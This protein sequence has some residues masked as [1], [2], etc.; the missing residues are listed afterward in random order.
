[1][2]VHQ[3]SAVMDLQA[4]FVVVRQASVVEEGLHFAMAEDHPLAIEVGHPLV[5]E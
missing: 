3:A 4:A 1:M 2:E 5:V